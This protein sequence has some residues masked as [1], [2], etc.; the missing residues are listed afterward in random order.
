[1]LA[2]VSIGLSCVYTTAW[3]RR[4][5]SVGIGDAPSDLTLQ[6]TLLLEAF[7]YITAIL[8]DIVNMSC[9][10]CCVIAILADVD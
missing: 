6:P 1:M 3:R 2:S 7:I 5:S 9:E 10:S 8:P 4:V